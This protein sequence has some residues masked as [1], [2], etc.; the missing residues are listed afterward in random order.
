MTNIVSYPRPF[1]GDAGGKPI[2][3]GK[4][5]IGTANQDPVT[6]PISC[7]WDEALTVPATQPLSITGGYVTNIGSRAAVYVSPDSYSIRV[8]GRGGV[9]VDYVPEL[10]DTTLRTD[11]ASATG[12]SM[13][14][15]K[16]AGTGATTRTVQAKAR[17]VISVTDFGAVGDGVTND[18][19]AIQAAINY[20]QL[21]KAWVH[22]PAVTNGYM[23]SGLTIG[24][25]G[26][27]YTCHFIGDGF[28]PSMAA[29]SG[30]TGQYTGQSML[31]L[32]AGSN[33]SLITVNADAAPP[34]FKNMTF[35]GN[36]SSQS[37]TSHCINMADASAAAYYRYTCWMEDCL[38]TSGRTS[39]LFIGTNR[40]A[41]YY[42]NV[43]VQ[44]CGTATSDPA[45]NV[46]CFDQ[47]F[48]NCQIGPN[49]GVGMYLGTVTQIQ[50][51]DCVMFMNTTG[52][53]VTNGVGHLQATNCAFDSNTQYGTI[54]VG[55]TTTDGGRVFSNC[56]WR[57]NSTATNNTYSDIKIDSDRRVTLTG[58]TFG[59]KETN[60]NGVK[61]CIE[62]A[63]T[64]QAPYARVISPIWETITG[65]PYVTSF[66][67]SDSSM[68]MVGTR[69]AYIGRPG[70]QIIT[71]MINDTER[72]RVD[73][74]GTKVSAKFYLPKDDGTLQTSSAT[75]AGA[76][77]PSNAN[78]V[79]GDFYF[80]S[81]TPGSANQRLYVKSAGAWVG[82]V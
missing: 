54:I 72:L 48:K 43:W 37:G 11:L 12:S 51:S 5:Y 71:A 69:D 47:Q 70:N 36:G 8:E 77:A 59:G 62:F 53:Q 2:D 49:T 50:L 75:Y 31:K 40:G 67:S 41:G 44:Y 21:I 46:R 39:G 13:I 15:F 79:N 34:M 18:T 24:T 65:T 66:T 27:N 4:L 16:Q 14:G 19:A 82:I 26:T 32:I 81:D 10:S 61:Y 6:H 1:Y 25:T 73:A 35:N 52:M 33:T 63:S 38:V 78:G 55:S 3:S 68:M 58:C 56:H 45:V 57:R 28:D 9:L 7:F 42:S 80:R 22:F 64:T 76:G 17:E 74:T 60:T 29:Q 20:A 30:I 23:V